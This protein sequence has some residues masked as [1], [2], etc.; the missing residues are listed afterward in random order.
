MT[1]TGD[2]YLPSA[3]TV[4]LDPD[5]QPNAL[6][7]ITL[8]PSTGSVT[9][10]VVGPPITPG[11][12]L[13]TPIPADV[14]LDTVGI[15][16]ANET[17]KLKTTSATG[18]DG[19]FVQ[20][21][22]PPG[23][24]VVTYEKFGYET[25]S[26]EMEVRAG[27]TTQVPDTGDP[28]T[29]GRI[30]LPPASPESIKL[31]GKVSVTVRDQ[32]NG[33]LL[34]SS[35]PTV[36]YSNDL[37]TDHPPD[38]PVAAGFAF[39][40]GIDPGVATF[41]VKAANFATQK[42][43]VKVI[44]KVT[45]DITVSLQRNPV[46][47]GIVRDSQS[48]PIVVPGLAVKATPLNN[49]TGA[50]EQQAAVSRTVTDATLSTTT[51]MITSLTAGFT[52][53]DVGRGVFGPNIP[54]KAKIKTVISPTEA[55]I[56]PAPTAAAS[57]QTVITLGN[58]GQY[59]FD[60]T[61]QPGTWNLQAS[62][63]G[64]V[65]SPPITVEVF[66]GQTV[67]KDISIQQFGGIKVDV[68]APNTTDGSLVHVSGATVSLSG[69]PT[70]RPDQTTG[71][72]DP[73]TFDAL[74]SGLYTVTARMANF[75]EASTQA[76]VGLDGTVSK[77][78][79][80]TPTTPAK[81]SLSGRIVYDDNG[82][83]KPV[84]N[85]RVSVSGVS[86]PPNRNPPPAFETIRSTTDEVPTFNDGTFTIDTKVFDFTLGDVHVVPDPNVSPATFVEQT[87]PNTP[88]WGASPSG[89]PRDFVVQP[90]SGTVT[91]SITYDPS[92]ASDPK[93]AV[94]GTITSPA[95][96]GIS[97]TVSDTGLIGLRDPRVTSGGVNPIKPGD[98]SVVFTRAGFEPAFPTAFSSGSFTVTPGGTV[99]LSA[100]LEK[101]GSASVSVT[102]TDSQNASNFVPPTARVTLTR[103][104]FSASQVVNRVGTTVPSL[105]A[106]FD[107]LVASGGSY[108]IDVHSVGCT[109]ATG[110]VTVPPGE[111]EPTT[112]TSD[113]LGSISGTVLSK[114]NAAS[115]ITVAVQGATVST[116]DPSGRTF[117]ATTDA[118]GNY[119][120]GGVVIGTDPTADIDGLHPGTYTI[121]ASA[122]G[123]Q[124]PTVPP[125]ATIDNTSTGEDDVTV[126]ITMIAI[127]ATVNGFVTENSSSGA[128]IVGA[129]VTATSAAAGRTVTFVTTASTGAYSFTDLEPVLWTFTYT[130]PSHSSVFIN[131]TLT[132]G[133]TVRHDEALISRLNTISG[134][135]KSQFGTDTPAP[136]GGV[137]VHVVAT[138]DGNTTDT[139]VT[140]ANS[141]GA[142]SVPALN[143]GSYAVTFSKAGFTD[144]TQNVSVGN[145]QNF[146]LNQTMVA[147]Q[148]K[149][150]VTI[151]S[152]VGSTPIG[153][154]TVTIQPQSGKRGNRQQAVTGANGQAVFN[155]V[156]PSTYDV[157]I[158]AVNGHRTVLDT[159]TLAVPSGGTDVA[160]TF[161]IQEAHLSG[162]IKAQDTSSPATGLSPYN[163]QIYNGSSTTG[164]AAITAPT[165]ANGKYSVFVPGRVDGY[166]FKFV[167]DANHNSD[168]V[169]VAATTGTDVTSPAG[170]YTFV[171]FASIAAT[172]GST[173]AAPTGSHYDYTTAIDGGAPFAGTTHTF[174]N[175]TAGNHTVN[176]TRTLVTG[177][178][179]SPPTTTTGT[180]STKDNAV[181]LTVGQ[182]GTDS[183]NFP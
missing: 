183:F 34:T 117:T 9:G 21:H 26:A 11:Q 116:T 157:T 154:T 62:A 150:T 40:S 36:T 13:P 156:P 37:N 171:K 182:A 10:F 93:T 65:D 24:Y 67:Q 38:Q 107:D 120:F 85:A 17:V 55:D 145:G 72:R 91:G 44:P 90:K 74:V 82:T 110:A 155:Q 47:T 178:S 22:V 5:F 167:L 141:T 161:T 109:D 70:T 59:T 142:Y 28:A 166:T 103:G 119:F 115:T 23:R 61:L 35:V 136:E 4:D 60:G 88:I 48:F 78:L 46:V 71:D 169:H 172:V 81:A 2:G 174:S 20:N 135:V 42:V 102:C 56:D 52:A 151:V 80:I 6:L 147:I 57:G 158:T 159:A 86:Y 33:D 149:T 112:I 76:L 84:A 121:T 96:T 168:D 130:A 101:H 89:A 173:A 58:P 138:S 8:T 32:R 143:D 179:G 153:G 108:S 94:I 160:K 118:N 162:T 139:T 75:N 1:V 54:D 27:Q 170:D 31:T 140:S 87:F 123:Q 134:V 7:Q 131:F 144:V 50:T 137:D 19:K 133:A 175:L 122:D 128:G 69:G 63:P 12:P 164:T 152:A 114:I 30:R 29:T 39:F 111:A 45:V 98:Y 95:G 181:T 79:L 25:Q 18:T 51:P 104:S 68:L 177:P 97:I 15:T 163:V 129:T 180:P 176:Y 41:T 43:L 83:L 73:V 92:T 14:G 146:V 165:D 127:P 105:T 66:L 16:I 3:Q 148:A 113:K 124:P 132:A 99:D 106:T 100:V 77:S 126:G 53:A 125:Q 64:Y 49:D